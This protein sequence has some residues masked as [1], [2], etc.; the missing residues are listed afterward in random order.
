[1]FDE[2]LAE[3]ITD[4]VVSTCMQCGAKSDRISNCQEATCNMLLVQCEACALRNTPTAAHQ[5]AA[6]STNYR[7]NNSARGAKAAAP[8]APRPRPSMTRKVCGNA[9]GKNHARKN[10]DL[11]SGPDPGHSNKQQH[12]V[13]LREQAQTRNTQL[14][15]Y[16]A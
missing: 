16:N 9:S 3:R 5:A 11:A 2:R 7:S 4:D 8:A 13:G 14:E 1:V 10:R 6:R 12:R 15:T